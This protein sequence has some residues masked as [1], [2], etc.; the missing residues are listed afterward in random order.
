MKTY[1][2]TFGQSHAHAY[3]GVT[4]DKDCVVSI[5]ATDKEEARTKMF[6]A[7]GPKWSMQYDN[8]P[9]MSYFPRGVIKLN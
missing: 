7:F 5:D 3:G 6:D 4:Y 8:L 1:Y 2:F 9:D